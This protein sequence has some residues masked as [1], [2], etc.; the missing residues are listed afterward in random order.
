MIKYLLIAGL[1]YVIYRYFD[2]ADKIGS[3]KAK[4]R[5]EPKE[6]GKGD[7]DDFVDFEEIDD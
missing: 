7:P 6:R 4:P 1:V 5:I 3:G 2:L